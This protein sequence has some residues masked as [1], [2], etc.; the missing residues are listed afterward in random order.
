MTPKVKRFLY[1]MF[2]GCAAMVLGVTVAVRDTSLD[3]EL[4]SY[5]G[6]LGGLAII[7]NAL[8]LIT[9]NGKGDGG[10]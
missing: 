4:L 3:T 2:I 7:I 5:L 10:T 6:V 9:E 8:P 1:L